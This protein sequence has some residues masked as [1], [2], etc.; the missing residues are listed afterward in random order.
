[1]VIRLLPY[2]DEHMT[3][4]QKPDGSLLRTHH[5]INKPKSIWDRKR[6]QVARALGYKDPERHGKYIIQTHLVKLEN[7]GG[8][9]LVG[10]YMDLEKYQPKQKYLRNTDKVVMV[11][12]LK[13]MMRL[14]LSTKD[15]PRKSEHRIL[16]SL[17]DICIE[18][19]GRI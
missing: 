19:E 9:H 16:T 2:G 7:G 13:F 4:H 17:G 10:R 15:N 3:I 18:A 8:Y 14:F 12:V 6:V 1:V 11:L 5:S